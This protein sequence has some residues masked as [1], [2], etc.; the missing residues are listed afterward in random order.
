MG[1][2]RLVAVDARL[3]KSLREYLRGKFGS[4][5]LLSMD[6]NPATCDTFRHQ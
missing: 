3:G 2:Q 5:R 1:L 4:L 6:E